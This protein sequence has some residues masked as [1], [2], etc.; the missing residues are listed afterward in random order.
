MT[1]KTAEIRTG[2]TEETNRDHR[3]TH[4]SGAFVVLAEAKGYR[5]M[6]ET[7]HV[8]LRPL[9]PLEGATGRRL[10]FRSADGAMKAAEKAMTA[11]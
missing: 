9:V 11:A 5:R 7:W 2:W 1:A 4:A 8:Y 10:A 6:D 3:F